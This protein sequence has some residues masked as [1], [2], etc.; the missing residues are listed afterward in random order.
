[1]TIKSS[2]GKAE[3]ALRVVLDNLPEE[4]QF[5][6][7]Q[8]QETSRN[9]PYRVRRRLRQAADR[10]DAAE[11]AATEMSP[12][13]SFVLKLA[14]NAE[15][16]NAKAEE[17]NTGSAKASFPP[18]TETAVQAV[19]ANPPT[20]DAAVQAVPAVQAV[21]H[22]TPP[23]YSAIMDQLRQAVAT[24]AVPAGY[25]HAVAA[26]FPEKCSDEFCRD[27]EY[28]RSLEINS[29]TKKPS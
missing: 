4:G 23:S 21:L 28:Y 19:V 10:L 16:E 8:K 25:L 5:D 17:A 9:G 13:E 7:H 6:H 18:T 22:S 20:S 29:T 24:Q 15:Q 2:A 26:L 27:V 3:I 12:E 14:K 11:K 1:M